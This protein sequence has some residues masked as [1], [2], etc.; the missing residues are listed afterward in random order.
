MVLGY[1][2]Q[3]MSNVCIRI[4]D[5]LYRLPKKKNFG[6]CSAPSTIRFCRK[7]CFFK[8]NFHSFKKNNSFY[9]ILFITF[10]QKEF[11]HQHNLFSFWNN[12]NVKAFF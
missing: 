2:L 7:P 10:F 6:I 5:F 4:F 12:V 11:A 3:N 1:K 9:N 8:K